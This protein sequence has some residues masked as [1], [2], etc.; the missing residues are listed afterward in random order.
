MLENSG[1][2][3]SLRDVVCDPQNLNPQHMALCLKAL[4]QICAQSRSV[5]SGVCGS[6]LPQV[7]GQNRLNIYEACI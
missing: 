1:I 3:N 5:A 2:V 7:Q 6:T 4:G